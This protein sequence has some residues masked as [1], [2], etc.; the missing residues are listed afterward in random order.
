MSR[1]C[2]CGR[3]GDREADGIFVVDFHGHKAR[4]ARLNGAVV[5]LVSHALVIQVRAAELTRVAGEISR[6]VSKG[7]RRDAP[8]PLP[9]E[10]EAFPERLVV[11]QDTPPP[12][13][14]RTL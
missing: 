9:L 12:A 2:R 8:F 5:F 7:L 10:A 1:Y 6:F 4:V 11:C 14:K 13:H 3:G